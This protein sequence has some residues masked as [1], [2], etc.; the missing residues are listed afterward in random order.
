MHDILVSQAQNIIIP[1]TS[2]IFNLLR[3]HVLKKK[4]AI[5]PAISIFLYK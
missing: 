2:C 4:K 5:F 1:D 3:P